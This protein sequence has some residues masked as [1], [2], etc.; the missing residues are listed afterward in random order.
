[1]Q[2]NENFSTTMVKHPTSLLT[3]IH[4][5]RNVSISHQSVSKVPQDAK[6]CLPLRSRHPF[7]TLFKSAFWMLSKSLQERLFPCSRQC[8]F[9]CSKAWTNGFCSFIQIVQDYKNSCV[10]S[11]CR[12]TAKKDENGLFAPLYLRTGEYQKNTSWWSQ[13]VNGLLLIRVV[14]M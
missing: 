2:F 1:M 10:A 12:L 13:R 4:A 8:N 7:G 5:A 14:W 6:P 3:P 11:K 9:C